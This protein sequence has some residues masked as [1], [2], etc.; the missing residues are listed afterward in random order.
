MLNPVKHLV[1]VGVA[2]RSTEVLRLAQDD[3]FALSR[4]AG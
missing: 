4:Y 1:V 3:T 2:E